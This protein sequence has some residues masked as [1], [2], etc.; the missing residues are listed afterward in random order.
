M[1]NPHVRPLL[2][3]WFSESC[4]ET[5]ITTVQKKK[6]NITNHEHS[7]TVGTSTPQTMYAERKVLVNHC[8]FSV[9]ML[10]KHGE[11]EAAANNAADQLHAQR[12][13]SERKRLDE[14][15]L[16]VCSLKSAER[17]LT[18]LWGLG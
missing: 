9:E 18:F 1:N 15:Y 2:L 4:S 10:L 5:Y 13:F 6:K 3:V 16:E 17:Y 14:I 8:R 7:V 12:C 11:R